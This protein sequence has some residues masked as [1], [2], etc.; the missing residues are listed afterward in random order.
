MT[1][2]VR[3]DF[4]RGEAAVGLTWLGIAALLSVFLEVVYLGFR[5]N[6]PVLG[7]VAVPYTIVIAFL[8][9]MVLSKTA[10]L[11]T[12]RT[13]IAGVPLWCWIA[14][15]WGLTMGVAITG[16]QLVG[17]SVRSVVLFIAGVA[18]GSWPLLRG[19]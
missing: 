5:V 3:T 4:T 14:G 9:T 19:R 10:L 12:P 2:W 11:W 15:Y 13:L 1:R 7:T 17:S 6:L 16:D 18:G 8:F